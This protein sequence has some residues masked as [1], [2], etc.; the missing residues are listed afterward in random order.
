[1]F[2]LYFLIIKSADKVETITSG[3]ELEILSHSTN[4]IPKYGNIKINKIDLS[5]YKYQKIEDCTDKM[6]D[7]ISNE[8][9]L[10]KI[11][12]KRK[13]QFAEIENNENR[14]TNIEK[15][16]W[17]L[18]FKISK[19]NLVKHFFKL[20]IIYNLFS[21]EHITY[22]SIYNMKKMQYFDINKKLIE[23]FCI[24][25]IRNNPKEIDGPNLDTK[26]SVR[27]KSQIKI[28]YVNFNRNFMN[29]VAKTVESCSIVYL[30][31]YFR[32]FYKNID[33]SKLGCI[34]GIKGVFDLV[35]IEMTF[36]SYE[37]KVLIKFMPDIEMYKALAT[38]RNIPEC[39]FGKLHYNITYSLTKFEYIIVLLFGKLSNIFNIKFIPLYKLQIIHALR[40][41]LRCVLYSFL[42][43]KKFHR[44][45]F[46]DFDGIKF[47]AFL[48]YVKSMGGSLES[49]E[50][51]N[52]SVCEK[53]FFA[54]EE[55]EKKIFDL[56]G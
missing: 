41:H 24:E 26:I 46:N 19:A 47:L 1:M 48:S 22:E 15:H 28:L 56:T 7:I 55:Y 14:S 6:F 11:S 21:N 9:F 52:E 25:L 53:N 20:S 35:I 43:D 4:Y 50:G 17:N 5:Q 49:F 30:G 32:S 8:L 27:D 37:F 31:V 44:L 12:H 54:I 36:S 13:I 10:L 23:Y 45:D 42:K 40:Y 39:V 18:I 34:S 16:L 38:M 29:Y 2:C 33:K 3:K 51:Y